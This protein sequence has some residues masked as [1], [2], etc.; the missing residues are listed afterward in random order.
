MRDTWNPETYHRFQQERSQ[1]FYDLCG[2]VR[3][4]HSM[5]ILDLGCGPGELTRHLHERFG[6]RE[7]IGLD[8][9]ENM[10]A[11]ATP[12]AGNGLRFVKGRIEE[13]TVG[14]EFDLVFSSA[15]LQWVADHEKILTMYAAKLSRGGQIAVQIPYNEVSPFH[16]AARE[17]AREFVG[18]LGRFVL[19][20]A[21][22][23]PERYARLLYDLGFAE[24]QVLLRVYP[25]VLA[26]LDAVVEWY[27]GSMLTEYE[28]R[29]EPAMYEKFVMR[30]R[31]VLGQ[32]FADERPFFFP[33]PRVFLWAKK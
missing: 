6:A 14:G 8:S 7:T 26:S 30:Y 4:Q 24:Q 1:P 10:L 31:E 17:V 19:G 15:A 3:P 18:P 33:F 28:S 27:R 32:R 5:R 25:Y 16:A 13:C 2:M 23:A 11:K 12:L 29:L 22:L 9:S 21:G 20:H